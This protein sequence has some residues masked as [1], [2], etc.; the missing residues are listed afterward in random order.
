MLYPIATIFNADK[1]YFGLLI[2]TLDVTKEMT[3]YRIAFVIA[4]LFFCFTGYDIWA[5]QGAFLYKPTVPTLGILLIVLGLFMTGTGIFRPNI[6]KITKYTCPKCKE[7]ITR[8]EN[9]EPNC[10]ICKTKTSH[11]Q[12]T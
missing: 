1:R 2:F 8:A 7:I 10:P 4:G 3:K 11:L 9:A 6:F 5:K 12:D